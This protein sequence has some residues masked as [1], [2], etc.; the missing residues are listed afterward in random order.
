MDGR[1]INH[2]LPLIIC[3]LSHP[4]KFK[5]IKSSTSETIRFTN[6]GQLSG[7]PI[8]ELCWQGAI[9]CT[10]KC[11]FCT[12]FECESAAVPTRLLHGGEGWC[13]IE[14]HWFTKSVIMRLTDKVPRPF[15]HFKQELYIRIPRKPWAAHIPMLLILQ[16]NTCASSACTSLISV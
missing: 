15:E 13:N 2:L 4:S 16:S 9:L 3:Y 1:L 14:Q 10:R 5:W 8:T 11:W 12:N 6:W 7:L